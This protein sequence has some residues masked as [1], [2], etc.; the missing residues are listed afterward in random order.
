MFNW[1][2]KIREVEKIVN[3][4]K[5]TNTRKNIHD[6]TEEDAESIIR[7]VKGKDYGSFIVDEISFEPKLM[8]SGQQ[9]TF[10]GESII[11]ICY[12]GGSHYDGYLMPFHNL[13]VIKWLYLNGFEISDLLDEAYSRFD[14]LEKEFDEMWNKYCKEDC[15]KYFN[16]FFDKQEKNK[17]N[18]SEDS[19]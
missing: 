7:Y 10:S 12:R 6:L 13:K 19:N 18:G 17:N 15:E 16:E 14:S 3:V 9:I 1:I 5:E 4:Y 11:G 2:K 8:G